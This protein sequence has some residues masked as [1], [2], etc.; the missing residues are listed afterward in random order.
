MKVHNQNLEISQ[1]QS[2]KCGKSPSEAVNG[3]TWWKKIGAI[4]SF[5][6]FLGLNGIINSSMIQHEKGY[7]S[8]NIPFNIIYTPS[9]LRNFGS[10]NG[11]SYSNMSHCVQAQDRL[12]HDLTKNFKSRFISMSGT[13][14]VTVRKWRKASLVHVMCHLLHLFLTTHS[15]FDLLYS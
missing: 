9:C 13:A 6:F 8:E 10:V 3:V 15:Q 11:D 14:N 5:F 7:K 2:N 4:K 12:Q 1:C